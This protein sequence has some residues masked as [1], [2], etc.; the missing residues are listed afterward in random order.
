MQRNPQRCKGCPQGLQPACKLAMISDAMLCLHRQKLSAIQCSIMHRAVCHLLPCT[1][2]QTPSQ[3]SW[4][5][6][7][8]PLAWQMIQ[9]ARSLQLLLHTLQHMLAL[10]GSLHTRLQSQHPRLL[11]LL[12]FVCQRTQHLRLLHGLQPL[13]L[14]RPGMAANLAC[15]M[16]GGRRKMRQGETGKI[17]RRCSLQLYA[18]KLQCRGIRAKV[19]TAARTETTLIRPHQQRSQPSILLAKTLQI[20]S[21]P[22]A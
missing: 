21:G 12:H 6:Q 5:L 7:P 9:D 22:R 20:P 17:Q 8:Q 13:H 15:C 2:L 16:P 14:E 3:P 1:A 11:S 4:H 10:Q 19:L 18:T